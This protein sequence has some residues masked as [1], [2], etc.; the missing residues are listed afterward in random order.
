MTLQIQKTKPNKSLQATRD[1]ALSS[2][3]R[4]TLAG[5]ACLSSRSATRT[6]FHRDALALERSGFAVCNQRPG[7][8]CRFSC[9][10]TIASAGNLLARLASVH[11]YIF[12]RASGQYRL[13]FSWHCFAVE[14]P[15][16]ALHPTAGALATFNVTFHLF[17][18]VALHHCRR[19]LWVSL[20]R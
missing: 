4:F 18:V 13:V 7:I 12:R 14:W 17:P 8:G 19:R 6:I 9:L 5:P 2:A 11:P 10:L 16:T 15:N 20:I 3:S 1:G